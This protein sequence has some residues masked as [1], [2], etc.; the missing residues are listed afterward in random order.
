L[1]A[2]FTADP[3]G[4]LGLEE[5]L[6]NTRIPGFV[7]GWRYGGWREVVRVFERRMMVLASLRYTIAVSV[8]LAVGLLATLAVLWG[9]APS[10]SR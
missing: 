5:T 3:F 9:A 4:V 1:D 6:S 8:A 10:R 2:I 7:E